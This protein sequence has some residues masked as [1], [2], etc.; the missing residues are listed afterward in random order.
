MKDSEAYNTFE[1]VSSDYQI[2]TVKFKGS[3]RANQ[4]KSDIIKKYNWSEF[5]QD[6]QLRDRYTVEV[7]KRF[8][9]LQGK[10]SAETATTSYYQNILEASN[11][12]VG[13]FS[14][15]TEETSLG[16]LGDWLYC[17]KQK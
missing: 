14:M 16:A 1:I 7:Q 3:L 11:Y 13:F 8:E 9:I 4:Q 17:K 5:T 6:S 10:T 2:V 12:A 15:N